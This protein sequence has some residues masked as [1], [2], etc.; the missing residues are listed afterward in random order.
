MSM[1]LHRSEVNERTANIAG[2]ANANLDFHAAD[3]G[4]HPIRSDDIFSGLFVTLGLID[5]M[6]PAGAMI[7]LALRG[8]EF[9]SGAGV[10]CQVPNALI[11]S[12]PFSFD[13]RAAVG[14]FRASC[15]R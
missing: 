12:K 5:A 3:L 10:A 8:E 11:P 4:S 2:M 9:N 14:R 7:D 13:V 1:R 6:P 15:R